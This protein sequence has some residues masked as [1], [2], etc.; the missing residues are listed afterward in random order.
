M[1]TDPAPPLLDADQ[2]RPWASWSLF[3]RSHDGIRP[4]GSVR[5]PPFAIRLLVADPHGALPMLRPPTA[6]VAQGET[7][8]ARGTFQI[9]PPTVVPIL[10][11]CSRRG[12][13]IPDLFGRSSLPTLVSS[14]SRGARLRPGTAR[15]GLAQAGPL[16]RPRAVHRCRERADPLRHSPQPRRE[17]REPGLPPIGALSVLPVEPPA[18]VHQAFL[19][20]AFRDALDA[21]RAAPAW[22]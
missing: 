16:L 21:L 15:F 12:A 7:G 13:T 8:R 18:L 20:L 6:S 10:P 17:P 2:G 1:P 5:G 19:T 22:P 4:P 9:R 11:P 14:G 3:R